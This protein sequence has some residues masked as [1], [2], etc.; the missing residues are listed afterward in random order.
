MI[1]SRITRGQLEG[2]ASLVGVSVDVRALNSAGTRHKV[3][4]NPVDVKDADG[5]RKYQRTS[6]SAF[7]ST[8]R[9]HAVCWHGFRDYFRACFSV[10]PEATFRTAVDVWRGREDFEERYRASGHR[11]VGAPIAPYK[12]CEV[13][14][15]P[16]SGIAE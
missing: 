3:K 7:N 6:A 14:V 5:N 15:C 4:V 2:A 8:R 16:D 13:C 10:A 12:A 1:A 9:V 11:V